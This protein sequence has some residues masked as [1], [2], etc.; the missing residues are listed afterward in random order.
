MGSRLARVLWLKEG[1]QTH[2]PL[3]LD[4]RE[5][6]YLMVVGLLCLSAL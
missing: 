3:T 2:Q 5:V 4:Q 6:T 1:N